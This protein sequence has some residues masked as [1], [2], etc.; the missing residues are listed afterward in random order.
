MSGGHFEY[1]DSRLK[2]DIFGW[3]DKP[4]NAFEDKE[5][6]E[7]VLDVLDLIHDYDWYVSGDTSRKTYLKAKADFKKKWFGNRDLRV[8]S[9]IDDTINEVRTELYETFGFD[10]NGGDE[11]NA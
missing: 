9:I 4:T 10:T 3:S 5:I 2:S 8:K 6:S 1:T 11:D 7:L